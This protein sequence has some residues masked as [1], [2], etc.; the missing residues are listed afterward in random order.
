MDQLG[1]ADRLHRLPHTRIPHIPIDT[2]RGPLVP[3]DL[4][5]LRTPFPYIML[6][7]QARFLEFL[8]EEAA[9]YPT[10]R[11]VRG[12]GVRRLVV[13]GGVVRGVRWRGGRRLARGA[14]RRDR[15]G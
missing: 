13:E 3:V 5:L 6:V 9:R 4:S 8:E 15:R 11:L 12:A 14:R 2:P 10:F 7:H 1:L